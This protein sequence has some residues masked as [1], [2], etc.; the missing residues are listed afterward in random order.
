MYTNLCTLPKLK[1]NFDLSTFTGSIV[2]MSLSLKF[3]DLHSSHKEKFLSGKECKLTQTM[4]ES[5][6][7]AAIALFI[8]LFLKAKF[9][10]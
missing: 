6:V 1:H 7:K 4:I 5:K 10:V 2:V 3:T 9:R 8:L